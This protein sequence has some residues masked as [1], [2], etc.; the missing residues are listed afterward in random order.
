MDPITHRFT[1]SALAQQAQGRSFSVRYRLSPQYTFPSAL[2]DAL[3]SYLS[4]VSPPPGAFHTAIPPSQI[5][6]SGDSSGGGLAASLLLLL[7]T[8]HRVGITHLRFHGKDVPVTCP[9]GLAL[10]SPWLDISRALPSVIRNV[11]YD[12]IAP[13][14]TDLTVPHPDFPHDSI[15]PTSPPRA[16]TYCEAMMVN[17]PLVSPLAAHA[18][19]WRGSPPVYVSVGWESMQDESEVFSRRVHEA[20]GT[21]VFDGY[22]GMPHCFAVFPFN[23]AGRTAFSNW[24]RFCR[25]SASSGVRRRDCGTWT[26][27]FGEMRNV[28][29][30]R[31]GTRDGEWHGR[32]IDLDDETVN[33]MLTIQREWREKLEGSLRARCKASQ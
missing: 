19:H 21:V 3:I 32:D 31:L 13:P 7:L 5:I 4:L 24:A 1:T 16:E 30:S 26:D 27:K 23:A 10:S 9:G 11:R 15:W 8:L 28:K 2:L 18:E 12:I 33:R 22:K 20:G 17:H 29:L 14:N 6:I 25:D